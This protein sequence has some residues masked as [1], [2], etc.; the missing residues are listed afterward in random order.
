MTE[1][2][3]HGALGK[4]F[5][6]KHRFFIGKPIDAIRALMANRKGFSVD[7]RKWGQ[8]GRLYEIICDGEL[9]E[10]KEQFELEGTIKTIHIA[11]TIM[12]TSNSARIIVGA[13]MIVASFYFPGSGTAFQQF[14]NSTLIGAG[15][16][17]VIGGI[18]GLLFPPP[19]PQFESSVQGKSFI[20][21]SLE[22]SAVQ[23]VV[24]PLGYGRLR[25]GS[26]VISTALEP[27]R[28]G[29]SGFEPRKF[30]QHPFPPGGEETLHHY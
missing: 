15:V 8:K 16:S 25:L 13:L 19:V 18:M 3:L 30:R 22:N 20:F 2:I 21:S 28:M 12:G 23:G 4:K 29:R 1:V 14:M 11:P 6:K 10:S 17:L 5:G 9:L 7:F 26:K 24:I 27:T